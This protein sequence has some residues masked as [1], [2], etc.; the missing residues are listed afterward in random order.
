MQAKH[1]DSG[2][3]LPSL[4]TRLSTNSIAD[5]AVA[6]EYFS[7]GSRPGLPCRRGRIGLS[8]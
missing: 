7:A 6:L 3:A 2:T 8:I 5:V 1:S 4:S